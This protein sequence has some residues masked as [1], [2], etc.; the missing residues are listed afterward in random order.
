MNRMNRFQAILVTVLVVG[1]PLFGHQSAAAVQVLRFPTPEPQDQKALR[2]G[3]LFSADGKTLAGFDGDGAVAGAWGTWDTQTALPIQSRGETWVPIGLRRVGTRVL[4]IEK[5]PN[6]EPRKFALLRDATPGSHTVSDLVMPAAALT[7]SGWYSKAPSRLTLACTEHLAACLSCT[8]DGEPDEAPVRDGS[9]TATP[10]AFVGEVL[11]FD[12]RSGTL[13]RGLKS[14]QDPVAGATAA[15]VADL[16]FS[17]DGKR[18]AAVVSNGSVVVWTCADGKLVNT[19]TL[20]S[21]RGT[22]EPLKFYVAG[23]NPARLGDHKLVW[24]GNEEVLTTIVP[25]PESGAARVRRLVRWRLSSKTPDAL[26][27]AGAASKPGAVSSGSV[28]DPA[29]DRKATATQPLTFIACSPDGTRGILVLGSVEKGKHAVEGLEVVDLTTKTPIGQL[30]VPALNSVNSVAFSPDSGRVALGIRS[31]AILVTTMSRLE[32]FARENKS[33]IDLISIDTSVANNDRPGAGRNKNAKAEKT[34]PAARL[35]S[36]ETEFRLPRTGV[37][38]KT[39]LS[40]V[41]R[42]WHPDS[43]HDV[44]AAIGLGGL[45]TLRCSSAECKNGSDYELA[46]AALQKQL[47]DD[48]SRADDEFVQEVIPVPGIKGCIFARPARPKNPLAATRYEDAR[49][50]HALIANDNSLVRIEV[51]YPHQ[52][53]AE[54]YAPLREMLLGLRWESQYAFDPFEDLGWIGVVPEGLRP[55]PFTTLVLTP[56]GDLGK[57]GTQWVPGDVAPEPIVWITPRFDAVDDLSLD[58]A[59]TGEKNWYRVASMFAKGLGGAAVQSQPFSGAG[60][61]GW[62][63]VVSRADS[64]LTYYLV[65]F[66]G[67]VEKGDP[68]FTSHRAKV[69][70]FAMVSTDRSEEWIPKFRAVAR[71]LSRKES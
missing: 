12:P 68:F 63:L 67:P 6:S 59:R 23:D 15:K 42:Y 14:P 27:W 48:V 57:H 20:D 64:K 71:S 28:P 56:T 62:E 24:I 8:D 69:R 34:P 70:V 1:A 26:E 65:I 60:T 18:V 11:L 21:P 50:M 4:L 5:G 58:D 25:K 38:L 13:I 54:L 35:A 31:G 51:R 17:P 44:P 66:G 46:R 49:V 16:C 7:K 55:V 41:P 3:L 33:I 9:S 10:L 47:I 43:N 39:R 30:R 29:A 53:S 37:F 61:A 36:G 19:L 32:G 45:A 40:V 52:N 2:I 22:Y